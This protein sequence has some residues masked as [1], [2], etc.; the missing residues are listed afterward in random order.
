MRL[1]AS[2]HHES[3]APGV[4]LHHCSNGAVL[5]V[6]R[7]AQCGPYAIQCARALLSGH[8]HL[9]S[10]CLWRSRLVALGWHRRNPRYIKCVYSHAARRALPELNMSTAPSLPLLRFMPQA[11]HSTSTQ[12]QRCQATTGNLCRAP[13]AATSLLLCWA[14]AVAGWTSQALQRCT[15]AMLLL[16]AGSMML[17]MQFHAWQRCCWKGRC[18]LDSL[19]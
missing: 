7:Q 4:D 1:T 14:F 19:E 5:C 8:E 11:M 3:V 10:S 15:A 6:M 13:A 2:T 17:T 9:L 12:L 18:P 16:S